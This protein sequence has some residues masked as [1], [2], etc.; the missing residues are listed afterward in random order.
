MEPHIGTYFIDTVH[1]MKY[2]SDQILPDIPY[3]IAAIKVFSA[4]SRLH[5]LLQQMN[6]AYHVTKTQKHKLL[7][8]EE[9]S[10]QLTDHYIAVTLETPSINATYTSPNRNLYHIN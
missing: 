3:I 8:L 5:S 7:C 9:S 2:L 6:A 10:G 4:V 1:V